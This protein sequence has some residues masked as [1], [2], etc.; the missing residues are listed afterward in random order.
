MP[1]YSKVDVGELNHDGSMM[2]TNR[3]SPLVWLIGDAA[4]LDFRS[5]FELLNATATVIQF[6][7]AQEAWREPIGLDRHPDVIIIAASRPGMIRARDV[8]QLQCRLPLVGMVALLGSWCEGEARTGRPVPGVSR[9]YWYDFPNWWRRQLE[10]FASGHCPDWALPA[11]ADD[12]DCAKTW[13]RQVSEPAAG[14][15]VLQTTCWETG[16]V[17]ADVLRAS[18]YATVWGPRGRQGASVRGAAAGIW[19]GRQL[20]EPELCQL[21]EFS[22][23]LAKDA[24]PV[25]ALADFPRRDRCVAAMQAG[26]AAVLAKPWLNTELLQALERVTQRKDGPATVPQKRA[27]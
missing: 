14:L 21:A 4:H 10:L 18:G 22:K 13:P 26:A 20:D 11:T 25:I 16:D 9:C 12:R 1:R 27:A 8:Q 3:K 15:I 17:L 5:S 24:A 7:D 6:K 23:Q 2:S 19:E